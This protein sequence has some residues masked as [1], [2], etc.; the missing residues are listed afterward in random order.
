M[1]IVPRR[2]RAEAVPLSVPFGVQ[3]MDIVSTYA[4]RNEI[5][6]KVFPHF[7]VLAA[8]PGRNFFLLHTDWGGISG[9]LVRG[10]GLTPCA[11]ELRRKGGGL[12]VALQVGNPGNLK[13]RGLLGMGVG[14]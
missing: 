9:G 3:V 7:L 11:D 13:G 6:S 4:N 1:S 12:G 2:L 10:E 8:A 5:P 14:R